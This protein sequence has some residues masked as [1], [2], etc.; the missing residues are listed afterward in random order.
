MKKSQGFTLIELVVVIVILGIL[1]AVAAPKFINLQDDAN[2]AKLQATIGAF[3]SGVNLA[4]LKWRAKGSPSALADRNDIQLYGSSSDGQVDIN[5]DGWP[6]QSWPGNDSALSLNNVN[7][8]I[9]VWEV[10]IDQATGTVDNDTSDTYQTSYL[11]A[12][13]CSFVLTENPDFGFEYDSTTGEVTRI[14]L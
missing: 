11:G 3:R 6:A 4:H 7:D 14:S 5:T 12:N 2:E 9:S 8:C 1:A 10:L 13:D